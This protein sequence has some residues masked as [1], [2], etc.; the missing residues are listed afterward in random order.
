MGFLGVAYRFGGTTTA[1]FDC[2]GFIQYVF[3]KTYAVN[4]PRTSSVQATVG[5]HVD[6]AHLQKGDLVFFNTRGNNISH[7]GMYVGNNRFIHAPRTGKRI[8]ITDLSNKYWNSKYVTARRIKKTDGKI[9]SENN[10]KPAKIDKPVEKKPV[11]KKVTDN[12][13]PADKKANDKKTANK[14]LADTKKTVDK[15]AADK[16]QTNKK[17][18][19]NKKTTDK[20]QTGKKV[21]DKKKT[22]DKKT[23]NKK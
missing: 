17:V 8:E 11:D 23:S 14:K 1:G 18:V 5:T 10:N 20:K 9:L 21:A 16:K 15:K 6:R 2:S 19:D 13:K 22:A 4:L 7:V 3:K 12:K